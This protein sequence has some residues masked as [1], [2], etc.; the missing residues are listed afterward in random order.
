MTI[1]FIILNVVLYSNFT[2]KND[3]AKLNSFKH[4]AGLFSYEIL[5]NLTIDIVFSIYAT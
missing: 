2:Q 3:A 4:R 1:T 5:K